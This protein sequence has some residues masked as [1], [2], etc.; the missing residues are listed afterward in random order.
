[1]YK[2]HTEQK[3]GVIGAAEAQQTLPCHTW[4]WHQV[5][6]AMRVEWAAQLVTE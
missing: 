5:W 4:G 3:K 2:P 6:K 1:M